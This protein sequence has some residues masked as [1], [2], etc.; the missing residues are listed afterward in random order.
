MNPNFWRDFFACFWGTLFVDVRD[1][2]TH[3]RPLPVNPREI[4]DGYIAWSA[5][6]SS[7]WFH[8]FQ[9]A[10]RDV[11]AWHE[12]TGEP[13]SLVGVRTI[14]NWVRVGIG[15]SVIEKTAHGWYADAD[16]GPDGRGH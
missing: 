4:V 3:N 16:A 13:P 10:V 11:I 12:R 8:A 6:Q 9:S 14:G 1:C 15:P 7:G 2:V 5:Y